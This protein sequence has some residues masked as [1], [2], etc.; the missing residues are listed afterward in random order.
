MRE[1]EALSQGDSV[2]SVLLIDHEGLLRDGA[3]PGLPADYL[4]AIDRLKQRK[5]GPEER[6]VVEA[7]AQVACAVIE[8]A[9]RSMPLPA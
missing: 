3:S 7:L 8:L 1:A 6:S 4:A 2:C 5:P 9:G